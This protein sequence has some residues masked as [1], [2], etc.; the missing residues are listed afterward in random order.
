MIS[1][2]PPLKLVPL[3][4]ST[5]QMKQGDLAV[6]LESLRAQLTD[7]NV[8]AVVGPPITECTRAV[9]ET[10]VASGKKVPVI[11]ESAGS[12]GAVGWTE[13][14]G[15]I[16]IFRLST[17]V[18]RRASE[19][20]S[21]LNEALA[22]KVEI[23]L[24]VEQDRGSPQAT[25]GEHAYQEVQSHV[26]SWRAAVDSGL[27][28]AL[29]YPLNGVSE[30]FA[31]FKEIAARPSVVLLL[32]LGDAYRRIADEFFLKSEGVIAPP[33]ALLGGW[34]NAYAMDKPF[35]ERGYFLRICSKSP[36][37]ILIPAGHPRE[38]SSLATHSVY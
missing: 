25:Y 35:R 27:A 16:P 33:K 17:G 28:R 34:M 37:S 1:Q 38:Q 2:V 29:Y 24:L 10:V 26:T 6:L 12:E 19:I 9:L 15:E 21:F 23:V 22:A 7:G 3:S 4:A 31:D 18:E 36:T 11:I 30:T 32:G 20:A 5:Q 8:L 14:N 13:H